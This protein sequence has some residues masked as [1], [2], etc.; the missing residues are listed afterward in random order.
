MF[1]TDMNNAFVFTD[2]QK[3]MKC[4][5]EWSDNSTMNFTSWDTDQPK[6]KKYENCMV[7]HKTK[8]IDL[9]CDGS[10]A[11]YYICEGT[12]TTTT[13]CP[14]CKSANCITDVSIS[15]I[16]TFNSN[17]YCVLIIY[18]NKLLLKPPWVTLHPSYIDPTAFSLT[19]S[20]LNIHSLFLKVIF[21]ILLCEFLFYFRTI[22]LM[23][24]YLIH[25]NLSVRNYNF[26]QFIYNRTLMLNF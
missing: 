7:L 19:I 12:L 9:P 10:Y 22:I 15:C 4:G 11:A 23:L 2:G 16:L 24:Y 20:Q 14:I 1:L 6:E 26:L 13:P 3:I 25:L 18:N 8:W 17:I 5:Y 21:N